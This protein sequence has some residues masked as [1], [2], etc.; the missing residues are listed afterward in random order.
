MNKWIIVGLGNPGEKYRWTRHNIGFMVIDTIA[1]KYNAS[2][3][4]GFEA[5]YSVVD[6]FGKRCYLVKP[7]TYMNLSGKAVSE[8][9]DYF[10]IPK[11]NTVVVHDDLDMEF[12]RIKV[13][14]GG[15]SGGHKGINSVISCLSFED[16]IRVKM[17]IGKPLS[18]DVSSFVLSDFNKVEK[19]VLK[20]FVELGVSA[21]LSILERDVK[22][23]MNLYNNK[24]ITQEVQERCQP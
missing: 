23:A 10:D 3:K 24:K 20:D 19:A 1:D 21:T 16:F 4:G 15:S 14:I 18:G 6:L 17:G 5:D 2:F 7:Q 22:Y 13:K 11:E 12:G 8:I 9:S